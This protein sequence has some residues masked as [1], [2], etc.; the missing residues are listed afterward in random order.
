MLQSLSENAEGI[1]N[2]LWI[3]VLGF[4]LA[5]FLALAIGANDVANSFATSVGAKVLTL[6]QACILASIFEMLGCFLIGQHVSETIRKGIVDPE[7]FADDPAELM[8][9]MLTALATSTIWLFIATFFKLPVSGTHSV[10]GAL[11]GFT[12]VARGADSV[13]WWAV[14][15][16]AMSWV[17]SPLLSG[18]VSVTLFLVVRKFILN[19]ENSVEAG[20]AALPLFYSVTVGINLFSV[21]YKGSPLLHF[22]E[23]P[24][25]GCFVIVVGGGIVCA[26][27]VYVFLVPWTRRHVYGYSRLENETEH[28]V[29]PAAAAV[30][31]SAEAGSSSKKAHNKLD[32]DPHISPNLLPIRSESTAS[33]LAVRTEVPDD[34]GLE[35]AATEKL[36]STLQVLTAVF[37]SFSHG[38]NDV[39]NAIGPMIAIYTVWNTGEVSQSSDIP[40]WLLALGGVGIV[41]GL[42]V[43]GRR[44]IETVGSDLTA[45]TPSRGFSIEIGAAL[46]VLVAS[47]VGLPIST[48]H[49]K[50]GSVVGV[51]RVEGKSSV[52]WSLFRNIAISWIVTVPF[53]GLTAA[54]LMAALLPAL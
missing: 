9:G 37:G 13:K 23:I 41:L 6:K 29:T 54:A 11:V 8:L 20:L 31:A 33:L 28:T 30:M 27:L 2:V 12:L 25:W 38:G 24:L 47:N 3:L 22:D 4:I 15:K 39:S 40:Y 14:G 19:R 21:T 49:C 16:I 7:T 35:V 43:W 32:I 5:F 50:V 26:A 18:F 10:V 34:N 1:G 46:T 36:F 45:M 52:N 53:C 51:G 44:V 17:L 48:T 42:W